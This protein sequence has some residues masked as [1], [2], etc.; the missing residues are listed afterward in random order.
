MNE[1][2]VLQSATPLLLLD[3]TKSYTLM[4]M[5]FKCCNF[6]HLHIINCAVNCVDATFSLLNTLTFLLMYLFRKPTSFIVGSRFLY[7]A[8][9]LRALSVELPGRLCEDLPVPWSGILHG[10]CMKMTRLDLCV[11]EWLIR[12]QQEG[13]CKWANASSS[14]ITISL[15]KYIFHFNSFGDTA[16]KIIILISTFWVDY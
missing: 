6:L 7:A 8:T 4:L 15:P 1:A 11:M 14:V 3:A 13:G 10:W 16:N 2:R 5:I 12:F 9:E